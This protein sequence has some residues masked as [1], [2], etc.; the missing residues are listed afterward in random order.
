MRVDSLLWVRILG[1]AVSCIFALSC[2]SLDAASGQNAAPQ[3]SSVVVPMRIDA[4]VV[5][6]YGTYTSG[7][8]DSV[9]IRFSITNEFES[10]ICLTPGDVRP[11]SV[12]YAY[13]IQIFDSIGNQVEQRGVL[14]SG[15]EVEQVFFLIP[16]GEAVEVTYFIGD[17]VD[18]ERGSSYDIRHD[19]GGYICRALDEGYF[20]DTRP[21]STVRRPE[22]NDVA[23]YFFELKSVEI[24]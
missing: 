9:Q 22:P 5:F 13:Q 12:P 7:E 10:S 14:N 23:A 1:P 3:N 18:W 19:F 6:P 8:E 24:Q 21:N 2:S 4:R 11:V 16:P 17:L 15:S 20:F